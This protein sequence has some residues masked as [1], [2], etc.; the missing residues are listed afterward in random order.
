MIHL[1]LCSTYTSALKRPGVLGLN[2]LRNVIN[3]ILMLDHKIAECSL[4]QLAVLLSSGLGTILTIPRDTFA[5][6]TARLL[7]GQLH[8][9]EMKKDRTKNCHLR[10]N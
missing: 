9:D 5:A 10:S 4:L 2:L 7:L 1:G 6:M 3:E 8:E